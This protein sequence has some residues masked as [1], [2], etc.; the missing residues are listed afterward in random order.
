[1]PKMVLAEHPEWTPEQ[2]RDFLGVE[3]RKVMG[4]RDRDRL[5][6]LDV[7]QYVP[8]NTAPQVP[9]RPRAEGEKHSDGPMVQVVGFLARAGN[10]N[11]GKAFRVVLPQLIRWRDMGNVVEQ[12][13]LSIRNA[14]KLMRK[15]EASSYLRVVPEVGESNADRSG[16]PDGDPA[17][18]GN[19]LEPA[20]SAEA[21]AGESGCAGVP[22]GCGES[23]ADVLPPAVREAPIG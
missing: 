4:P 11:D 14:C 1:M 5:R 2:L 8:A 19:E 17:V 21:R 20:S 3:L 22:E 18:T 7:A 23:A 16:E 6:A 9:Q 10:E 12:L 15:E 13:R